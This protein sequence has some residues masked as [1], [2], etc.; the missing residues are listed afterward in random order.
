[1]PQLLHSVVH[2]FREVSSKFFFLRIGRTQALNAHGRIVRAVEKRDAVAA[3]EAM[4]FRL[5]HVAQSYRAAAAQI[6]RREMPS[7]G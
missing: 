1:M 6:A 4:R 5:L 7:P 2:L 3:S